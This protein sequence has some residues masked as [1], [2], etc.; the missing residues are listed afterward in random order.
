MI[1]KA[2]DKAEFRDP[3]FLFFIDVKNRFLK[4]I[5]EYRGLN[6]SLRLLRVAVDA[7]NSFLNIEQIELIYRG[8]SQQEF[9]SLVFDLLS[10]NVTTH[11]FYQK[12]R[13]KFAEV[14][15]QIRTKKGQKALHAYMQALDALAK[16]DQLGLKL[17]FLFKKHHLTDYSI[18]RRISEMISVLKNQEIRDINIL[19]QMVNRNYYI[20]EHLGK[21]IGVPPTRSNAKTYGLM[22]QYLVLRHKY[23]KSYIHF[24]KL[25]RILKDWGK[26]YTVIQDIRQQ[27]PL[28]KY[29]Q[30]TEFKVKL[31]GLS[32]Y[33]AYKPYLT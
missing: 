24:E 33:Q 32:V 2:I 11:Y 3:E 5:D 8:K 28:L 27:H 21:I 12:V 6:H 17:L 4:G 31:Q 26:C 19:I 9:Y 1:A 20:F 29:K 10:R 22:L 23:Q 30:P 16:Q 7:Q 25:L 15:P 14:L 13:E 18:L